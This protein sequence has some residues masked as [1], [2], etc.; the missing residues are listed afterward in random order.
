MAAPKI[1][2]G[3][4]QPGTKL[5][6]KPNISNYKD[7][8]KYQAALNDFYAKST[9][10]EAVKYRTDELTKKYGSLKD[11]DGKA[12]FTPT[13]I[14]ALAEG[15][16]PPA[17]LDKAVTDWATA[18][19][20]EATNYDWNNF[21]GGI[22]S[23]AAQNLLSSFVK[24]PSQ[25]DSALTFKS[26]GVELTPEQ[27]EANTKA[28]E[29]KAAKAEKDTAA[30]ENYDPNAGTWDPSKNTVDTPF[31]NMLSGLVSGYKNPYAADYVNPL[32]AVEKPT[33]TNIKTPFK[34]NAIPQDLVNLFNSAGT[35]YAGGNNPQTKGTSLGSGLLKLYQP[36]TTDS[37][38]QLAK[39]GAPDTTSTTL[40]KITGDG[41]TVVNSNGSTAIGG[42]KDTV[43]SGAG[44]DTIKTPITDEVPPKTDEVPPKTEVVPPVVPLVVTPKT[45]VK[46]TPWE[47]EGI[48][49]DQYNS[50]QAENARIE[51]ERQAG[52]KALADKAAAEQKAINDARI[53]D[54]QKA[55]EDARLAAEK[56][57]AAKTVVLNPSNGGPTSAI[58]NPT[59]A[60]RDLG[61]QQV[62]L[63]PNTAVS[64]PGW[65]VLA[66]DTV[67]PISSAQ[68]VSP[69]TLQQIAAQQNNT[70]TDPKSYTVSGGLELP[71]DVFASAQ[72][73]LGPL[74]ISNLG[75]VI[76]P[77]AMNSNAGGVASLVG[78]QVT[79]QPR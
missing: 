70:A 42:E 23:V 20:K 51:L 73:N 3:Y 79:V 35:D 17:S 52:I 21:S 24:D 32:T 27:K 61:P 76:S 45:E 38:G 67:S 44:I 49:E 39:P 68:T 54:E 46:R 77:G 9:D 36:S 57:A 50:W 11:A 28:L 58:V 72:N 65:G 41:T 25:V 14:K 64:T 75:A 48:T 43:S 16:E 66:R 69:T 78:P 71:K 18:K 22:G 62:T 59:P 56:A 8:K 40:P 10:P 13:Y 34:N 53:A 2:T 15:V 6:V 7:T 74:N 31:G 19:M 60:Q 30:L 1:T 12:I 37:S 5:I 4:T 26:S 33:L 47:E 55:I 29:D 63:D